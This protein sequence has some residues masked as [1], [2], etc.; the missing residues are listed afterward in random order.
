ML[1]VGRILAAAAFAD[2]IA[3]HTEL[4]LSP[5]GHLAGPADTVIGAERAVD[6]PILGSLDDIEAILHST[7]VDE[8]AICLS[9]GTRHCSSRSPGL[10]EDEGKVVR[11][12]TARS[13]VCRCRVGNIEDFDGIQVLSLVHGPDRTLGLLFKRLG[14]H[15]PRVRRPRAPQ[16]SPTHRD[17]GDAR[18]RRPS[19]LLPPGP[20]RSA[21][22][23]LHDRQV[24]HDGRRCGSPVRRRRGA[25]DTHGAAF[26]MKR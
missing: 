24:P 14:R 7:I 6:R 19:G 10:C 5:I 21:R 3:R 20:R 26:K 13:R 18:D 8:V 25:S 15:R 23:A 4:G 2:A 11:I 22:S 9:P 1:I 16:P 12:P 17:C